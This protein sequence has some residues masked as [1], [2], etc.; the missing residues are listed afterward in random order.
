MSNLDGLKAE[1]GALA[2]RRKTVEL[3]EIARIANQLSALGYAVKSRKVRHGTLFQ[4]EST[5]FMIC[6]HNPGSSHVKPCY[7]AA[8]LKAMA[9][10]DLF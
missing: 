7:V 6:G 8:F 10:L 4:V 2:Q 5:T 9:E 1:I 3:S